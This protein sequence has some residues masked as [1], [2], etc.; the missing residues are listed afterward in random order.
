MNE[1]YMQDDEFVIWAKHISKGD[2][3]TETTY[4]H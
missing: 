4:S 2:V 3:F 1:F